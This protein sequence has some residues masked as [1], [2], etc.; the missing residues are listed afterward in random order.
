MKE[1]E[2]RLALTQH[3]SGGA[4][5][6]GSE[7]SVGLFKTVDDLTATAKSLRDI[8]SELGMTGR[9]A[10]AA[11]DKLGGLASQLD[12]HSMALWN[13]ATIARR[14]QDALW[15]AKTRSTTLPDGDISP[16]E[17]GAIMAASLI[18][19][20]V[21]PALGV[22]EISH[23]G[24]EK[25]RARAAAAQEALNLLNRQMNEAAA[26]LARVTVPSNPPSTGR[27]SVSTDD[28][29][30]LTPSESST[31]TA[32]GTARRGTY[33]GSSP[34]T[35]SSPGDTSGVSPAPVSYDPGPAYSPPAGG[36][37]NPAP[38]TG[39]GIGGYNPPP[40]SAV[41][42]GTVTGIVPGSTSGPVTTFTGSG[43]G[44]VWGATSS[45]G[46]GASGGALAGGMAVGGAA[47]GAA[48]LGRGGGLGSGGA[49]AAIGSTSGRFGVASGAGSA[50]AGSSGF[51]AGSRAGST[52]GLS[53]TSGSGLAGG[54]SSASASGAAAGTR[55]G[56]TSG[57]MPMGGGGAGGAGSSKSR[58]AG[59]GGYLAPDLDIA[60]D[61]AP[62]ALGPGARAGSRSSLPVFAPEAVETDPDA[63]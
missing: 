11:W 15:A 60:D 1:A 30:L 53:G 20:L 44:N 50:R 63:W 62:V 16:V 47:L 40:S 18:I 27:R 3:V 17:K 28:P 25:A 42:D 41:S 14:A 34:S 22:A 43:T 32:T 35:W 55:A 24:E 58:K 45:A 10:D 8:G 39:P 57:G 52:S 46:Q 31:S 9:A 6:Q 5:S 29:L 2:R 21:G 26:D 56:A 12:G 37:G 54:S 19:P 51:G 48:G 38:V 7:D 13:I 49:G 61:A 36:G 33:G 4:F 59:G 23:L